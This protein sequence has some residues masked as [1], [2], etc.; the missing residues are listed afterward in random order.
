MPKIKKNL[1]PSKSRNLSFV[2]LSNDE[3]NFTSELKI[4]L[5]LL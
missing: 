4:D 5:I 3:I 1:D 2:N